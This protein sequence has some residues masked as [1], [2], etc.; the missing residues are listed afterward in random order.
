MR[1]LHYSLGFP[2]YRTGGLTKFCY[3]LMCEQVKEGDKVSLLWPGEIKLLDHSLH[4]K[5]NKPVNGIESYEV[6][7]P[8]PVSYDEGIVDIE[9]FMKEG[10]KRVY[11]SFLRAWKPEVIHVHTL[12]GLHKNFLVAARAQKIRLVFTTHDFFPICPK[13]TMFRSGDVCK[14][15]ED[16]SY[17]PTCNLTALSLKK[18]QMLQ[19]PVYRKMKENVIVKKMRKAQR[20]TYLSENIEE[21]GT[22]KRIPDDYLKLRSHYKS[23]LKMMDFVHYNSTLTKSIYDEYMGQFPGEVISITHADI[24]DHRKIKDF[25]HKTLRLTYLGPQSSAKGFF[26]L[27]SALD[28][29]WKERQNFCLNVFFQNPDLPPYIKQHDRYDYS[30]LETI[31]DHTDVVVTPSVWYETFGY[32]VL[33]ALSY[34]VP[35]IISDRV[36]ARDVVPE[37]G[38][39]VFHFERKEM[40]LLNVINNCTL[41]LLESANKEICASM[42]IRD[43]SIFN[44]SVKNELYE[45]FLL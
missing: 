32:T 24:K 18:L 25:H 44:N 3:D 36:G 19:S 43:I 8:V 41:N 38:G 5:K 39:M 27:K 7:N 1:I 23:M 9:A 35:V 16:C 42:E 34:G 10:D 15:V 28:E 45:S 29:L 30:Q 31:M 22:P 12:M 14:T 33:E 21:V 40:D 13:V 2:P 11:Y 17:C 6:I 26:F 4:I 20:D 37:G